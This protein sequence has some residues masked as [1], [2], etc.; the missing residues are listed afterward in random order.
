MHI[1]D[2][3]AGPRRLITYS[4]PCTRNGRDDRME[5]DSPMSVL[6][7]LSLRRAL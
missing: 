5:G 6:T 1:F 3:P 2:I 4:D 7:P